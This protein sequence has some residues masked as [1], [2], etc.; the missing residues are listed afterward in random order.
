MSRLKWVPGNYKALISS[1]Q[2]FYDPCP[3]PD[4]TN[5]F[6]RQVDL[7]WLYAPDSV[8]RKAYAFIETNQNKNKS[9]DQN[10]FAFNEL[11]HELRQDMLRRKIV[12]RSKLTAKGFKHHVA[13]PVR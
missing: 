8:I 13:N 6:L 11:A 12:E 5:E 7:C 4:S 10:N 1:L 3:K 2:S 9:E